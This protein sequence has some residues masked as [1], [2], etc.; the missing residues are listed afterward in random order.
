MLS[1]L[2]EIDESFPVPLLHKQDLE[3]LT[4]KFVEKAKICAEIENNEICS[5]VVGYTN[6]VVN[7]MAHISVVATRQEYLGRGMAVRL[8]REFSEIAFS[9]GLTAVHLYSDSRNEAAI[10][11][12]EK[13]GFERYVVSSKPRPKDVHLILRLN[14]SWE[15]Q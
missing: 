5:M 7:D 10:R 8:V 12:Y 4:E 6:N 14:N 2:K 11:I 13:V 3:N 9:E 15:E 1:F